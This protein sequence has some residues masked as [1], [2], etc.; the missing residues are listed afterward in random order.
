MS[1]LPQ[2]ERELV[3]AHERLR[4]GRWRRGR[5]RGLRPALGSFAAAAAVAVVVGVVAVVGSIG[6]ER[7]MVRR[8]V[9]HRAVGTGWPR[10]LL[11]DIDA[12]KAYALGGSLYL[13]EQVRPTSAATLVRLSTATGRTEARTE[14]GANVDDVVL[15]DGSLWVTT[16]RYPKHGD[17]G[18]ATLFRLDPE[19]L[20]VRS[21]L[22][23]PGFG[24]YSSGGSLAVAGGWLWV[25]GFAGLDRVLPSTGELSATVPV[26]G[27]RQ[28]TVASDPSGRVLLASAGNG[29]GLGFV[30]RR[31]PL[32]GA[33]IASS[34]EFEGVTEPALGGVIDGGVWFSESTGM[35]GYVGRLELTT[36]QP[37]RTQTPKIATNGI[38]AD[39][40]DGILWISQGAGGRQRNY[41]GD[42]VSGRSRA[43]FANSLLSQEI[44]FQTADAHYV[45]LSETPVGNDSHAV[46]LIRQPISPRC[47]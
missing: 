40:I 10:L 11:R 36:L 31:D 44:E 21:T 1:V 30:Q 29:D 39:V 42:P 5:W 16:T 19:S 25:G 45:Y 41:C 13:A 28:L 46:L 2:L 34:G 43:S 17:R 26:A 47:R 24:V 4:R 33:L 37:T 27:A 35:Q 3:I 7:H 38:S 23:L 6:G 20:D 15:A 8:S 14:L 32:T 22:V 9:E 18:T 12:V